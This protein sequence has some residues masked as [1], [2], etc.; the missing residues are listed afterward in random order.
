MTHYALKAC[1]GVDVKICVFLTWVLVEGGWSASRLRCFNS[2]EGTP[3]THGTEGWT[4]PSTGLSYVEKREYLSFQG[5]EL[6]PIQALVSRDA[7]CAMASPCMVI[8]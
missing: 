8:K 5:L 3:G 6:Q 2:W 1:G 4:A 7:E